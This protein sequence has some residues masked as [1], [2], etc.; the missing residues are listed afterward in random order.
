[1]SFNIRDRSSIKHEIEQTHVPEKTLALWSLGQAGMVI[2]NHH[3]DVIAIDPYLSHAIEKNHPGTEFTRRFP[4]VLEPEDILDID[5]ILVT[6]FH[7]DH[8]D[9]ETLLRVA[10]KRPDLPFY[11]PSVDARDIAAKYASLRRNVAP[12]I[13]HET[14]HIGDF[15][16]TPIASA[17]SEYEKNA[18]GHDRYIGYFIETNG[19]SF[20]HSGDTL[21]TAELEEEL[22][23]RKPDVMALPINGGDYSRLKRGIVPNMTFRDAADLY[24]SVGSDYLLPIHYDMFPNNTDNPAHFVD[25]MLQHYPGGKFHL[26]MPGERV[27]YM[28]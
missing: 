21:V 14:L 19:L 24:H 3:D 16:I 10:E 6:H 5:A 23:R 17:H 1:M 27:I 22:I 4:P 11:I 2:K 26:T 13:T 18:Q 25:Y 7:D 9:L 8:M 20:Y 12:A 28:K 15:A